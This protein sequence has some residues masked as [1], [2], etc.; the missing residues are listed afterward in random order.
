MVMMTK[1]DFKKYG[2]EFPA[3]TAEEQRRRKREGKDSSSHG[4]TY[5]AKRAPEGDIKHA[6][7][8]D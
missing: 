4:D 2:E 3:D 1:E 8:E 6:V 5:D 7:G